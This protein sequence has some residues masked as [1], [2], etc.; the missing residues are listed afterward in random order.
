M[1]GKQP[2]N[3]HPIQVRIAR[4]TDKLDKVKEF[5]K[6]GLGL[7]IITSFTKHN[8][9]TGV[10]FGIPGHDFH[11]EF[12]SHDKGIPCPAPTKE[13]LIVFYIP[14]KIEIDS[15]VRN[16]KGMGYEP[17]PPENPYWKEKG[18][19][20]EDPDGWRIVLMNTKGI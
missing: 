13:N 3:I 7:E 17:V 9:Y 19:T 2:N 20:Y 16:L 4:P 10:I 11:L 5:Y 15:L 8:G 14:D 1:N 18:F 6:N 12:I